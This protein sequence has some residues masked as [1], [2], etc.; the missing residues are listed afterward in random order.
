MFAFKA[1]YNGK[2][3]ELTDDYM[4]LA[5]S[6]GTKEY[7]NLSE[8]TMKNSDGG[9]YISLQ[10]I[11]DLK[12]GSSF[13]KDSIVA[14]DAKSFSN[15]IAADQLVY[16]NGVLAKVCVATTE[17]GF[18]DSGVCSEWLSEAMASDIV[19][20]KSVDIEPMTNI[21]FIASKGQKV[22]EGDPVLIFQNAYDEED[23]NLLLK[24]LNNDDGDVVEIG[25]S[26]IKS[27][28]TGII[29]DIK[30][31]RT[32]EIDECSESI[33]K[34]IKSYEANINKYKRI[35]SK[36]TNDVQFDSTE[37]LPQNG[38]L[39]NT[40]GIL[41]EIYMKY[42]DKISIGDKG[43]LTNANKCVYRNIYEDKDAP[44]TDFRP[45]EKIDQITSASSMDG[46]IITSIMKTG[47]ANKLMIELYRKVADIM[48]VKWVDLHELKEQ[49]EAKKKKK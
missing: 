33:K 34:L 20:M 23:A 25:R 48:G 8:Q 38:K 1:K 27:K 24:N 19:V 6:N 11:T 46:R 2:V 13:K 7:V 31:Y 18:E 17:D 44:Y 30:I 15:N 16:N 35:A 49:V 28:V 4:I 5:Y 29:S 9:F 40:S 43:V 26:V 36:C 12:K 21:Y 47:A 14:Y 32:C 3:E 10:L 41:I 45:N 22:S 42:H 39:K 37:K